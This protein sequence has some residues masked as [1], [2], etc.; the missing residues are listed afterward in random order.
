MADPEAP[1]NEE[2]HRM[3]DV[4]EGLIKLRD[5]PNFVLLMRYFRGLSQEALEEM[6]DVP[7]TDA[8]SISQLQVKA[9]VPQFIET[10]LD[11][12]IQQGLDVESQEEAE[13]ELDALAENYP[14]EET[15]GHPED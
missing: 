6:L 4:A 2:A 5:D 10:C 8:T 1:N 15:N 12:L 7:P 9:K 14:G 11:T 3:L 13:E